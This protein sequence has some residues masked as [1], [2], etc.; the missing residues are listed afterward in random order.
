MAHLPTFE[1]EILSPCTKTTR[2]KQ[3]LKQCLDM[4]EMLALDLGQPDAELGKPLAAYENE[5]ELGKHQGSC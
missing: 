2:N 3:R 1:E 4:E 5:F